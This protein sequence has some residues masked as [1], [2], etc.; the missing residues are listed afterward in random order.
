MKHGK[1]AIGALVMAVTAVLPAHADLFTVTERPAAQ[2]FAAD[3][4][5]FR[6]GEGVQMNRNSGT[7]SSIAAAAGWQ[8]LL[9]GEARGEAGAGAPGRAVRP[10]TMLEPALWLTIGVGVIL[11]GVVKL[12]VADGPG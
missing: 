6:I 1:L 9:G 12:S 2:D 4:F 7:F 8:P 3:T 5:G 10:A 11:I